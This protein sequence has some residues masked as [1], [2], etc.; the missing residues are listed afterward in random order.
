MGLKDVSI[1]KLKVAMLNGVV[2]IIFFFF[3]GRKEANLKS[4]PVTHDIEKLLR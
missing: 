3:F 2:F 4:H 1:A